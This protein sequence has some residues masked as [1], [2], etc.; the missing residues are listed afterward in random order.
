MQIL[1]LGG[2]GF[3]GEYIIASLRA[4]GAN[5]IVGGRFVQNDNQNIPINLHKMLHK[6]DWKVVLNQVDIVVNAVGILRERRGQN[7]DE[8]YDK[9]HNLAVQALAKACK[10]QG[11]RLIHIST[12]GLNANAKSGFI[13]SKYAGEQA[14][15]KSG[16]QANIVR[17]SILD[18][19][20][21]YGAKWFRRVATW[22]IQFVMQ[23]E[24]LVAP[25][26]VADL[27]EAVAKITQLPASTLPTITELG[28][29]EVMTIAQ[30]LNA[31]RRAYGKP[32]ALQI[33][34]P[35]FMV[36]LISH[37]LDFWAL[38]PLSFGH[39]ELMQGK[40]IPKTNQLPM[41]IGREPTALGVKNVLPIE[42]NFKFLYQK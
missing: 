41:I 28:G 12:F 24:G 23:T 38:T 27:G 8:T 2:N 4:Q 32:A 22:P 9:I 40:N 35:Q 31:L 13:R 11:V 37:V 39:F 6:D 34:V 1:V 18:G 17:A 16:A 33:V 36:H 25:M 20:G 3:I 21:G 26:Q 29:G 14:I 19:E 15:L 10:S 42:G 7:G 5:V 30:Y